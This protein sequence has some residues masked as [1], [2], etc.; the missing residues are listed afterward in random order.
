MCEL[1]IVRHRADAN[2]AAALRHTEHDG[3]MRTPLAL[4]FAVLA[5]YA[6][7]PSFVGLDMAG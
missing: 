5:C 7:D 3:F 4:P 2:L 6:A 1:G